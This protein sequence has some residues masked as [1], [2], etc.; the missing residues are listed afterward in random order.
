MIRFDESLTIA[1]AMKPIDMRVG[2]DGLITHALGTFQ[3]KLQSKTFFLFCN[4]KRDKV[5]GLYWDKNGF[6]LLHKRMEQGRFQFPRDYKNN[7]LLITREQLY[8]LLAGFDF[9]MMRDYPELDFSY[10]F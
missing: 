2:I 4:K 5:K 3:V 8:G 1:V 10:Y 7:Q 6:V 9:V